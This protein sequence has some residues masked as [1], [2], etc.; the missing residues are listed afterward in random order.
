MKGDA[1]NR[2]IGLK[3]R[4]LAALALLV[5]VS[6]GRSGLA[7]EPDSRI[8]TEVVLKSWGTPLRV[9]SRVS[10]TPIPVRVFR[11][12]TVEGD[13]LW[14]VAPGLRGWV[15]SDEVVPLDQALD[16]FGSEIQAHPS[17]YMLYLRRGFLRSRNNDFEN[18]Q[19]DFDEAI[20]IAPTYSGSYRERGL[21]WYKR[22]DYDRALVDFNEAIRLK[23]DFANAYDS[24][25]YVH[26][27]RKEL[28]RALRDAE[29]V[30]RLSSPG[31][32]SGYYLRSRVRCEMR[33][34][35]RALPD[36]N[37]AIR[38][39]PGDAEAFRVRGGVRILKGELELGLADCDEAIR[40]D[41]RDAFARNNRGM[42]RSLKGQNLLAIADFSEA[43]RLDPNNAQRFR[44]RAKAWTAE[45]HVDQTLADYAV[46]LKLE[47][48]DI[49]S[50]SYH[51]WLLATSPYPRLRDGKK[52]VAEA[53]HACE[54]EGW[55]CAGC[56]ETLAAANAEAGDFGE[57]VRWQ[58]KALG[59]KIASKAEGE[60]RFA[61]YQAKKPYHEVAKR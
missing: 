23:P 6:F 30:I 27:A 21:Y 17:D 50:L 3:G 41:P 31:T 58:E 10:L 49:P 33:D 34:L 22:K 55:K 40:L 44:I 4:R 12:V 20:R 29:E 57:A 48:D 11:V 36:L 28:D 8:G 43:I 32:A 25:A 15:R 13:W 1:T 46:A 60:S 42:A 37:E 52:A 7:D 45:G 47:P 16:Y 26:L 24:R 61:L 54:L 2:E 18:A 39:D 59:L 35:D 38:L 9:D 56:L 53:S 14:I 5:L 19:A 51:A